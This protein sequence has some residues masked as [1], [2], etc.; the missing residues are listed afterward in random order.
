MC[1]LCGIIGEMDSR[2]RTESIRGMNG[3]MAHRGPNASGFYEGKGIAL[4][5]RRLSIID[6]SE[7]SNQPFADATGRYQLVFNGEIYNYM[8]IRSELNDYS[9]TTLSDT[10]VILAAYMKWGSACVSRLQGMFAFAIWDAVESRL[11]MARDR[12]GVKPLYYYQQDG[13]LLIASEIRALLASGLV[14]RKIESLALEDYLKYQSVITPLTLV[15]GVMQLPAAHNADFR[16]GRLTVSRYWDITSAPQD[17]HDDIVVARR[18]IRDLL[19]A[20]VEKRLVSD[21]PIGAFLS[22]GIDST[23]VVA[24]MSKVSKKKPVAFTIGF[25]EKEYDETPYADLVASAYGVQHTKVM[26]EAD[27]FLQDLPTALNALDTP[28]GDGLNTFTVAKAIRQSGITVALTGV[29]GDELFAGYPIFRQY[30]RLHGLDGIF[31]TLAPIRHSL[32]MVIPDRDHRTQRLKQLL[33]SSSTD[34]AEIYPLLRQIQTPV[35][36][37]RLLKESSNAVYGSLEKI[38]ASQQPSVGAF[39]PYSQVSISEYMG[40]TQHVLLK[41][42]DQMS[43]AVSLEAR[44]PFFDTELVEYVIGLPDEFKKGA[45]PKSLMV[46]ALSPLIPEQIVHRKKMGFVL[47]YDRW[48]RKELKNFGDER[49]QSL[50]ARDHFHADRIRSYW[51]DYQANRR[52]I[53]WPDIWILLVLSHWLDAHGME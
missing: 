2:R 45:Y 47:P 44:E 24:I 12:F 16:A 22:G 30:S 10:E 23:A 32:A 43:M 48:I 36:V 14:P 20:S 51:N 19:F 37:R 17:R 40:Y 5:H 8:E 18:K 27:D 21:V 38:L 1:G 9:F 4:G 39:A 46:D 52:K 28:S 33:L 3:S 42:T 41:D 6:L 31:R 26:L 13:L 49:I 25:K 53:R 7:A 15:K 50:C 34:I 11:F 35:M 29:G